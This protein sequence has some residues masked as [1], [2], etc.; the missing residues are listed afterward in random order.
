MKFEMSV[1]IY[2]RPQGEHGGYC[3]AG[4][5][6]LRETQNVELSSLSDAAS[7][8]VKLHEFF[9]ALKAKGVGK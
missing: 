6:E 3:G 2:L 5:L 1:Q 7:I 9:E 8:L 4:Q